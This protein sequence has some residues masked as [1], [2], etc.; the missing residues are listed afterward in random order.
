MEDEKVC[1]FLAIFE[2]QNMKTADNISHHS[3]VQEN[4]SVKCF[5]I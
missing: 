2:P 4:L 1:I 3:L 5:R